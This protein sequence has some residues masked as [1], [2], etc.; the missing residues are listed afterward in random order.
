MCTNLRKGMCA[1]FLPTMLYSVRP[2]LNLAEKRE[3]R[4]RT[5]IEKPG[6]TWRKDCCEVECEV[7]CYSSYPVSVFK[8]AVQVSLTGRDLNFQGPACNCCHELQWEGH[9]LH[10]SVFFFLSVEDDLIMKLR[11]LLQYLYLYKVNIFLFLFQSRKSW[12]EETFF[13]RE[14]VKFIPSSRDLH[15]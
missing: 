9:W 10:F 1:C 5:D 2:L 3:H 13:K 15:R 12:I 11:V 7:D 4:S 14:C 8:S 6:E